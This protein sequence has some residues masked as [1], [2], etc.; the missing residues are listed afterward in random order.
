V[1]RELV[2]G[3][4]DLLVAATILA[5]LRNVPGSGFATALFAAAKLSPA[6]TLV[7]ASRRIW[8]E[9]MV[10]AAVL[11]AITLP[12]LFLWPDWIAA[13][14]SANRDATQLFPLFVRLPVGLIC[15]GYRRPW[16]VAAGAALLTPAFYFHSLVLLLPAARLGWTDRS[17]NRLA[18]A[19]KPHPAA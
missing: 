9:A 3:N 17:A 13:L 11:V 16:S 19:D 8:R 6:A 2:T 4:V 5:S 18:P 10:G 1:P 12:V 15:L 7:L 14:A